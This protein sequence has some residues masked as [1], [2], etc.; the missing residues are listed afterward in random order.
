MKQQLNSRL[1]ESPAAIKKDIMRAGKTLKLPANALRNI[2]TITAEKVAQKLS[3]KS[4]GSTQEQ[5][6]LIIAKEIKPFSED[7]SF[8]YKNRGKII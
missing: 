2:A 5:I 7:L 6:D 1:N 3:Q 8:I 4:H